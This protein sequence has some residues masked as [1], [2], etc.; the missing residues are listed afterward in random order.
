MKPKVSPSVARSAATKAKRNRAAA[1]ETPAP[2]RLGR[3]TVYRVD[4]LAAYI[5]RCRVNRVAA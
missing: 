2:H 4:D 3:K 5:A 1:G